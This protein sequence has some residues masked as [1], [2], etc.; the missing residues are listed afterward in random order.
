[1]RIVII[2]ASGHVGGYLVPRLVGAGHEVV[3][4]SRGLHEPYRPHRAWESVERVVLDREAEDA[5]GTFGGRIADLNADVVIDM[6][7]FT[8]ASASQL[9]EAIRGRVSLLLSCGTIWTHGSAVEVPVLEH[10]AQNPFGEYGVGKAEIER[11]LHAESRRPGGLRS[12]VL[13]PGHITGPGW[14]MIN[15][16]GNLDLTV[17]QKLAAGDE[18]VMPGFGLETVHHVHADDVAQ[19]FQRALERQNEAVGESFHLVSPRAVTLRGFAQAA[20]GWFGQEAR[21]RFVPFEEFAA[22]TTAEHAEASREHITRSHSMSIEKA[23][24]ML[25][26]AP[27]ST[28]LEA[29]AEGLQWLIDDGQLDVGGRTLAL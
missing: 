13:H 20:A 27:R 6:V 29:V 14:R 8:A 26:Y 22:Q 18:V 25:G 11:L 28:T 19:G 9:V 24:R 17:W 3:A 15:P 10:E 4:I 12:V 1:M 2:G 21:L 7:C 5:A 16:L 23:Q